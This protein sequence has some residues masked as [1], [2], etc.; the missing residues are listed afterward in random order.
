MSFSVTGNDMI[1]PPG[2]FSK[3]RVQV[4]DGMDT[5][6]YVIILTLISAHDN[7]DSVDSFHEFVVL[8]S[9]EELS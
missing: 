1:H 3:K 6:Q 9:D 8:I 4:F 2:N 5:W 7:A